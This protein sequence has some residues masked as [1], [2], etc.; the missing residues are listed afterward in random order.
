VPQFG[1]YL[2]PQSINTSAELRQAAQTIIG[3]VD[4][5]YIGTDNGVFSALPALIQVCQDAKKPLFSSDVTAA[6]NGG[7]FIANGFNY[8]TAGLATGDMVADILEGKRPAD[9]P[10]R[11]L[12]AAEMDLLVDLD[13]AANCGITI[14]Q[15]ILSQA[16]YIYQNGRLTQR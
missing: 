5:I 1:H 2:V 8:Y 15:N 4:G 12:T 16:N 13:A 3:R 9:M 11:F 7:C 10:T 14:P 6:V